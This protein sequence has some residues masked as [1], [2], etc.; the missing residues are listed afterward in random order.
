L[1][2]HR[3]IHNPRHP[4][5]DHRIVPPRLKSRNSF[6]QCTQDL[7]TSEVGT[8]EELWRQK[9]GDGLWTAPS[10]S[11]D[12]AHNLEYS[13]W[14]TLNRLRVGVSRCKYNQHRWGFLEGDSVNCVV[15]DDPHLLQCPLMTV[16]CNEEDLQ[17][18]NDNAI[19]VAEYW[20]GRV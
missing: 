5:Y 13:T 1:E 15:Q 10:E 2:R 3:Q 18:A 19:S 14:K 16:T 4:L 11:T 6:L 12:S 7:L 17:S 20:S 9:L 8:R